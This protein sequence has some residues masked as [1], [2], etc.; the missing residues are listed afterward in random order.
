V[1][2]ANDLPLFLHEQALRFAQGDKCI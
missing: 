1:R 2:E